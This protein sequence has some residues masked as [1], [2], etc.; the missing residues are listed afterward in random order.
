MVTFA[1]FCIVILGSFSA[2]FITFG[3]GEQVLPRIKS[4]SFSSSE[5]SPHCSTGSPL[6]FHRL[7]GSKELS[8]RDQVQ[9]VATELKA[10][11]ISDECHKFSLRQL[12]PLSELAV[13]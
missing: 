5:V 12:S 10:L 9:V 4:G 7:Q 13:Y 2:R 6:D 8:T 11:L 1:L 3:K